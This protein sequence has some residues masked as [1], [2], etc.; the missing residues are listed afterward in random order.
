MDV[1]STTPFYDKISLQDNSP[2]SV[3]CPAE[4]EVTSSMSPPPSPMRSANWSSAGVQVDY[5]RE[6]ISSPTQLTVAQKIAAIEKKKK[7][8]G[9]DMSSPPRA[10]K[11]TDITIN[12]STTTTTTGASTTEPYSPVRV[13]AA[14]S[15][16]FSPGGTRK[17]DPVERDKVR[18]SFC[19]DLVT[20]ID[21]SK[22]STQILMAVMTRDLAR[23][24]YD[25]FL[26]PKLDAHEITHSLI[27][28]GFKKVTSSCNAHCIVGTPDML[29]K[30]IFKRQYIDTKDVRILVVDE[31]HDLMRVTGLTPTKKQVCKL[32]DS[33]PDECSYISFSF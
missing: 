9:E 13:L 20:K 25:G 30:E 31:T 26:A 16:M 33:L 18:V 6:V 10:V 21:A 5:S 24:F 32:R 27:L 28:P 17:I 19:N 22:G 11:K 15:D 23:T 29:E 12:A 14:P 7:P 2:S 1:S 3:V 4:S 8:N